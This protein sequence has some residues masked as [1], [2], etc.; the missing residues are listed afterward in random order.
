MFKIH[1]DIRRFVS[2]FGYKAFKQQVY[3]GRIY[4]G[5]AQA[6]THCGVGGRTPALAENAAAAGKDNNVVD[7]EEVVLVLHFGN[8]PQLFSDQG[9]NR[10][11]SA[12]RVT[13]PFAF[14]S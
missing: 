2:V 12:F 4:F 11:W 13:L 3:L 7:G 10:Q 6:I 8:Q 1:V 5:N 9:L 14:L